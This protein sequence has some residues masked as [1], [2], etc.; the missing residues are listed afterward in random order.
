MARTT[1]S[2][3]APD[4]RQAR[5][6]LRDAG[7]LGI[8]LM[9][10]VLTIAAVGDGNATESFLKANISTADAYAF[11]QAK[12]IRQNDLQIA[13]RQYST[14][15]DTDGERLSP[16]ARA[17]IETRIAE[18]DATANRYESEPDPGDPDNPLKGE[19]KV[20]LLAQARDFEEKRD[21][22]R[23]KG[24]SYDY[25]QAFAQLGILLMSAAILIRMR[26]LALLAGG[27]GAVAALFL[28]N[29]IASAVEIPFVLT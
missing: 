16:E 2:I 25:S 17:T 10:L 6:L 7:A 22:A 21:H 29:A 1:P 14:L 28:A 24:A 23:V 3:P 19:G 8:A 20:Q 12:N 4:H 13:S 15:L 18:Y 26:E 27:V 9:A 11:F 5:D